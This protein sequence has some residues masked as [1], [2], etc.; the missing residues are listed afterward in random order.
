VDSEEAARH[1]VA[2]QDTNPRLDMATLP[3]GPG[4]E[5]ATAA[6]SR[7]DRRAGDR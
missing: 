6:H 2:T 3:F 5:A 4:Y 7:P 1:L